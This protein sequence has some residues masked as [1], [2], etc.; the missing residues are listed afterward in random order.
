VLHTLPRPAS[1]HARAASRLGAELDGP[2]DRGKGGPG[3]WL[4]LDEPELHLG[5]DV[6][7]PDLA[8]WRRARMPELPDTPAFQLPPDWVCE[9]LSPSTSAT[10]RAEKMPIYARENVGFAWLVDPLARTL[11]ALRLEAGRWVVLGTWRDDA[12]IRAE[13]F[14]AVEIGL[15]VLWER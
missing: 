1:R 14:D 2:F 4:I 10:D 3:G 7:V 9:V 5:S 11:E 6:L 13:P 15:A 8:G 12:K